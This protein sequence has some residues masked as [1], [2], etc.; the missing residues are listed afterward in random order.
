MF[1]R[2]VCIHL[3]AQVFY[4]GKQIGAKDQ[5]FTSYIQEQMAFALVAF[6]ALYV[7]QSTNCLLPCS[8]VNAL[9]CFDGLNIYLLF[10]CF[11]GCSSICGCDG[12]IQCHCPV[13]LCLQLGRGLQSPRWQY[14][15]NLVD[16]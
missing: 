2:L 11:V 10:Q 4:I 13:S 1:S 16:L 9:N 15:Q 8:T 7:Y 6:K 5:Y 3:C 12:S 14:R